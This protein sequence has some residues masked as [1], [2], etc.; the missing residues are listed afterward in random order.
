MNIPFMPFATD[1]RTNGYTVEVEL[2]SHNVQDYDS[3]VVSCFSGGRGFKIQS[4]KASF[5]SEQ[6]SVSM[7]FKEDSKIRVTFVVEQRNLNRF[8]YI[9]INGVMCGITQYPD[10][11]DFRQRLFG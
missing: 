7:L 2:A 10:N 9:Y 1:C 4:Q 11:D 8:V 6:S 3:L 5:S